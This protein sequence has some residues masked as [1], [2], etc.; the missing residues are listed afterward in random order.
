MW[1]SGRESQRL[2][3]EVGSPDPGC[4]LSAAI[5]QPARF[6]HPADGIGAVAAPEGRLGQVQKFGPFVPLDRLEVG[7]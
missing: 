3:G 1:G 4:V 5:S 2:P 6:Q 7:Q